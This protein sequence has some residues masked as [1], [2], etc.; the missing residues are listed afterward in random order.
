MVSIAA[1]ASEKVWLVVVAS[2]GIASNPASCPATRWFDGLP[3]PA[4]HPV[5]TA[6]TPA[7]ARYGNKPLN[8][9][10]RRRGLLALRSSLAVMRSLLEAVVDPL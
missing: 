4:A 1:G 5:A 7:I 8:V 10:D 3:H 9:P 2:L 6:S